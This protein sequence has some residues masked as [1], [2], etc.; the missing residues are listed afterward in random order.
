MG[1]TMEIEAVAPEVTETPVAGTEVQNPVTPENSESGTEATEEATKPQET[2]EQKRSK[3]QR[4]IDRKNAEIAAAR[5]EARLYRERLEA[6]EAQRNPQQQQRNYQGD[7][8]PRL[9]QFESIDDYNQANFEYAKRVIRAELAAEREA[10][11]QR[12]AEAEQGRKAETWQERQEAAAEKYPDFEEVIRESDAPITS[13]MGQAIIESDLGADI[14]YYLAQ[15]P[16][17]AKRIAQLPPIRQIAEIGKLEIKVGSPAQKTPTQAP[18]PIVPAGS[19]A[20]AEKDPSEMSPREFAEWR[21]KF[22]RR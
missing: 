14:A 12:K 2:E 6:L 18:E 20:K 3:Y 7:A 11:Q 8:P 5:T 9:E 22:R 16:K 19:K 21:K 1:T 10:E 17:E 13:Q 15:N 4:R